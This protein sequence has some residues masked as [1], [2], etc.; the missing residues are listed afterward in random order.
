M[1]EGF[2]N[3]LP[4]FNN[5]LSDLLFELFSI[6]IVSF[7]EFST[8]KPLKP[9][10]FNGSITATYLLLLF[11]LENRIVF[12]T[13]LSYVLLYDLV[14]IDFSYPDSTDYTN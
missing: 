2:L 8:P 5:S 9:C 10:V 14:Q 13:Q 12:L 1:M 6:K 11:K 4:K 3:Y 7:R